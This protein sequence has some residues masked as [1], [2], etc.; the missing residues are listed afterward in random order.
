M[1]DIQRES[2]T[3][4]AI[5]IFSVMDPAKAHKGLP[6][7]WPLATWELSLEA[8]TERLGVFVVSQSPWQDS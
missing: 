2:W 8:L 5:L 7:V 6:L 4:F 3:V 1:I